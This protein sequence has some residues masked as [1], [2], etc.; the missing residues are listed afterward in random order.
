MQLRALRHVRGS[1][2]SAAWT[3]STTL[4]LRRDKSV[5]RSPCGRGWKSRARGD[6]R[7][8]LEDLLVRSARTTRCRFCIHCRIESLLMFQ[9]NRRANDPPRLVLQ[10]Q[11]E[12]VRDVGRVRLA[13]CAFSSPT[14]SFAH[15]RVSRLTCDSSH[16]SL[17]T[18]HWQYPE[19]SGSSTETSVLR[20]A[21]V[22]S[23]PWKWTSR[24]RAAAPLSSRFPGA[25]RELIRPSPSRSLA[26][27]CLEQA[28]VREPISCASKMFLSLFCRVA[29]WGFTPA[30][31]FAKGKG[32]AEQ[33]GRP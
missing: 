22:V 7:A 18:M 28:G 13:L 2:K 31:G 10:L 33:S 25:R 29:F 8:R 6:P 15:S 17:R 23:H 12:H 21:D 30:T 11:W 1:L 14:T 9:R 3:T 27:L 32:K 26:C 24:S 16:S 5:G 20:S 19:P 4:A